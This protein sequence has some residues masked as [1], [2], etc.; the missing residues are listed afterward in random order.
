MAQATARDIMTTDVACIAPDTSVRRAAE[1]MLARRVSGLPVIDDE[2][3]LAGIVTEGDLMRRAELRNA[4]WP[5]GE[6]GERAGAGHEAYIRSHS[7]RARDVMTAAVASVPEE[8]PLSHIAA[9]FDRLDIKRVPVVRDARVVGIV[10]RS[11]LLRAIVS[12]PLDRTAAGDA[13]IRLA[14]LARLREDIG[15]AGPV[16]GVDV[17]GGLVHLRGSVRSQAE[18]DAVR[19]VVEG[20]RGVVG[21]EDH[22]DVVGVAPGDDR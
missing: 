15:L 21:I 5:G 10:S 6:S 19:V 14:I 20:V 16:P 1:I 4:P 8:A 3:R 2:G 17:A 12:A 7:W 22:L 9:L 11:D 13:A 18:R